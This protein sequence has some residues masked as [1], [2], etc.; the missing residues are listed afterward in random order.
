MTAPL[1]G[2]MLFTDFITFLNKVR[3][4]GFES[5]PYKRHLLTG[6]FHKIKNTCETEEEFQLK[7]KDFISILLSDANEARKLD[8]GEVYPT[9]YSKNHFIIE[10]IDRSNLQSRRNKR[11]I[12]QGETRR[13]YRCSPL[14]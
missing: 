2:E 8:M 3:G 5:I 7:S 10:K 4:K 14:G 6:F 12:V 11:I 9:F 13:R 1:S